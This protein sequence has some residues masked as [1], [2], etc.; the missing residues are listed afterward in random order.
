MTNLRTVRKLAIL[1]STGSIGVNTLDVIARHPDRYSVTYLTTYSQIDLLAKQIEKFHPKAVVVLDPE[2]AATLRASHGHLTE[3]LEGSD[4]LTEIA[5]S[6]DYDTLIGALVGFAG[7][8]PTLEAIRHGKRICIANK[9]TL[10][11]AGELLTALAKSSGSAILPVD[12][13]HSAIAQCLV[14]E[15]HRSI[16]KIILTASGG[17][18]RTR[19]KSSFDA[20]TLQEALKHPNWVMGQKI[21]IDSATL[22]NK[23]LEIIE[24]RWLFDLPYQKIEVIVHPQSIVHS[25]VEFVDGS[26]KAQLGAPDMRLPIQY[27]LEAPERLVESYELPDLLKTKP[28]EFSSP[29]PDKFPCLRLAREAGEMGGLY[30]CVLNAAN[31]VA[32]A[33]FIASR[34]GFNDIPKLIEQAVTEE[35]ASSSVPLDSS[36]SRSIAN[37]LDRIFA[38][39]ARVRIETSHRIE[40]IAKSETARA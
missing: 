9:E 4:A 10:V 1:G 36:S 39:D 27:A 40:Q 5:Q 13:E 33:A 30:P 21:T 38:T 25:M 12:S 28:L 3:V 20:I 11:V 29:D 16:K 32:V 17:P 8:K 35:G 31:E 6:P 19:D 14:G 18:F 26:V 22:M 2:K 37:G 7:L 15:E 34:I 24:A 23:G